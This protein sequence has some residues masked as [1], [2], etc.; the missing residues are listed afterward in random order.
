MLG[1][2]LMMHVGTELIGETA[3]PRFSR[4][5]VWRH[6]PAIIAQ[7]ADANKR[8]L[9]TV[10]FATI[11]S[12]EPSDTGSIEPKTLALSIEIATAQLAV[13]LAHRGS[14]STPSHREPYGLAIKF[15]A[16]RSQDLRGY[17]EN[18]VKE[19]VTGELFQLAP[20]NPHI[21]DGLREL[22]LHWDV[23]CSEAASAFVDNMGGFEGALA[24]L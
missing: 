21:K 5:Q 19:V 10:L 22:Y 14:V 4:I 17:L 23:W 13:L 7:S 18:S 6:L 9:I 1:T 15:A 24:G 3:T 8:D 20:A 16:F 2:P 12:S 11:A